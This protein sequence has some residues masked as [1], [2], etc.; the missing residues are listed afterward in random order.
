VEGAAKA[1]FYSKMK[2][3]LKTLLLTIG[4]FCGHCFWLNSALAL[5]WSASSLLSSTWNVAGSSADGNVLIIND[6]GN[7][8][9]YTSTNSGVTWTKDDFP[10]NS[11]AICGSLA[12]S[13]DG[14]KWV[15]S[16][17]D[18]WYLGSIYTSTNM[19]LTW[20][21]NNVGTALWGSVASSADGTKLV[22]V[23]GT[24]WVYQ[25]FDS[26]NTWTS[27]TLPIFT[28][29]W[30][31]VH[32][33]ADGTKLVVAGVLGPVCISTNS[34]VSWTIPANSPDA[35][36]QGITSSADGSKIAMVCGT[37]FIYTSADYGSTWQSNSVPGQWTGVAASADG[38]KL[39]G[40][41]YHVGVFTSTNWGM[42]WV[43]NTNL[44]LNSA[45]TQYGIAPFFGSIGNESSIKCSAD[46]VKLILFP[47][48]MFQPSVAFI[49]NDFIWTLYT[50]PAPQL[51]L[52]SSGTDLLLSWVVPSTNFV[53]QQCSDLTMTNWE[54]LTNAPA[55]NL[56]NL[57]NQVSVTPSNSSSFFRL[58]TP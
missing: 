37:N 14:S 6:Q 9:M 57:Q 13:A 3:R 54:S 21:S 46:G 28:N 8:S 33:S 42:S 51:N 39:F 4:V 45:Y 49:A 24:N 16:T 12:S 18:N 53:V 55:L 32:S 38:S 22:A 23:A 44:F 2:T 17:G 1:A 36:W 20:I 25:S 30:L 40:V 26:G 47:G 43:E 7:G 27:N 35:S 15:A 19:G 41:D 56:T 11:Y 50:T 10:L 52:S 5:T 34:G 48:M 31:F 29:Q 58:S